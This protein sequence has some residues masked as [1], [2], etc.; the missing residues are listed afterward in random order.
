[1]P[2]AVFDHYEYSFSHEGG[3]G[4]A[5]VPI[6]PEGD[7]FELA[8][9]NWVV[10]VKA[11]AEASAGS[12][13]ATG[14][15]SFVV[16]LGTETQ[17]TVQLYPEAS[18]GTGTLNYALAYPEGATVNSF[19]LTLL[20]GATE[21]DLKSGAAID[22]HSIAGSQTVGSGY[23]LARAALTRNG[24]Q[25]IKAQVVH[26]YKNMAT[27]LSMEFA[28]A[29]FRAIMV[30]SSADSGPGSLR[31]TIENAPAGSAIVLDL[32]EN[33]RVIT[34]TST[35]SITKNLTIYGGGAT[36]TQSGVI[37]SLAT[38]T[39]PVNTTITV[40]I[41][42]FHFKGGRATGSVSA[43]NSGG[44]VSTNRARLT[45]ESCVFSDNHAN[46]NGGAVYASNVRI[47]GSTFYG[48]SAD[49]SGGAVSGNG[50]FTGNIFYG[51]T[52]ATSPAVS[53][54][55]AVYYFNLTDSADWTLG[56]GDKLIG[57]LPVSPLTFR[58]LGGGAAL[59]ML[60]TQPSYAV[61]FYGRP[62]STGGAA[63]AAQTA[64]ATGGYIRDY[65]AIGSGSVGYSGAAPDVD[66]IV[67]G[68]VTLTALE[69]PD[70]AFKYW[71][72][73]GE[74]DPETS[75]TLVFN[76][77]AHA[78]IRAVFYV[79]IT[80]MGDNAPGSLRAALG[81]AGRG[82]G[83]V[84]PAGSALS[85]YGDLP[86]AAN[87]DIEGNGST[88]NLNGYHIVITG[89]AT[90]VRMSRLHF[91]G[92][93]TTV[94]STT[95]GSGGAIL[96][97][98]I[99]TVESCIFS[100]NQA[101]LSASYG[102]GA[103]SSTGSLTVLGSTFYKNSAVP[104]VGG[105]I[106]A[107]SGTT[108]L[109]GNLF[110][111]NTATAAANN[112]INGAVSSQGFNLSDQ[113]VSGLNHADDAV[114]AVLPFTIVSF[115]PFAGEAADGAI[116]E[117]PLVYPRVDFYG[118]EV[119]ANDAAAGAVQGKVTALGF[120]LD[121]AAQGPGDVQLKSGTVDADGMVSGPVTLKAVNTVAGTFRHW[122]V[123]GIQQPVQST[124]NE[125]ELDIQ[126][127]TVVRAVFAGTWTVIT[128]ANGGQGSFREAL[129]LATDGDTIVL[130]GQTI[131]LTETLSEITKDLTI[132]GNGATLTQS[133]FVVTNASNLLS[134]S[135]A[136]ASISRI[137]FKGGRVTT[138]GAGVRISPSGTLT[139]ES[140][141]FSDNRAINNSTAQ[142]GAVYAQGSALNIY[143]CTFYDNS[144]IGS[145]TSNGSGGAI[146]TSSAAN[147]VGNVF[148]GNT[149]S[150]TSAPIVSGTTAG[151]LN[152]S[153]GNLGGAAYTQISS[154][155]ILPGSFKPFVGAGA[156]TAI[157][158]KPGT[159]PAED[160][161]GI[162][163]PS[164]TAAAGAVQTSVAGFMLDYAAEGPG[165]VG[166]SG[167]TVDAEGLATS[168]S[169]TLT[170]SPNPGKDFLYWIVNG[171]PLPDQSTPTELVLS[172][173][174]HKTV[175][176]AFSTTWTVGSA[177]NSGT[178]SLR[179]AL[180]G[181]MDRDR[182]V[183][184]GQTIILVEPLP[185]IAKSIT[186]EGNG[187][188]LTQSG[189]A[190]DAESQLLYINSATAEVKI[191]RLL[192]KGGRA[193]ANGAAIQSAGAKLTLES[194]I[195]SD[196]N[197]A[198]G[199]AAT[200]G[201]ALYIS[202]T[203]SNV[204]VLGCTFYGNSATTT[205]TAQ[206]GAIF[207]NGNSAL[208]LT[209]N[210]FW[211]NTGGSY[212][213][214]RAS[215]S[216]AIVSGGYNITDTPIG[217]GAAQSGWAAGSTG[218]SQATMMPL[219]S[220]SFKPLGGGEALN[221]IG[222][223]PLS[224]PASDFNG[225]PITPGAASGAI[226]GATAPGYVLDYG[227]VG[228]G[229]VALVA[230]AVD[231]DGV[232]AALSS[233]TLKATPND[234]SAAF[235]RWLVN[236]TPDGETTDELT[237]IMDGHKTVRAVFSTTWTVSSVGDAGPGTLREAL[238]SASDGDTIYLP[239]NQTITLASALTI[240]K[241]IAI[242]GGGATLTTQTG[243]T[244]A[245][246]SQLL[247][248]ASAVEVG[249]SRLHFKG[250]RATTN[251][252]AIYNSTGKLTLESCIFSDN[253]TTNAAGNGGA[254][255]TAG[256][257][258][259]VTLS[260]CTFYGNAAGTTGGRGAAVYNAS[261]A[262][263]LTGN[264]FWGN[265][266]ND[267]SVLYSGGTTPVSG[268]FNVS[269]KATGTN[270]TT[271]S[272]WAFAGDT[273]AASLPV[274]PATF[275][276]FAGGG[277]T[278]IIT[279]RPLGYPS[280]DFYGIAIPPNGAAAGAVQTPAS[281]FILD[282]APQGPG[283]VT[284]T[285]GGT[286]DGDGL[287]ASGNSVT[288]TAAPDSGRT[289]INWTVNGT[290]QPA[291]TP[292]EKL[293][294]IMDA[295]KT[296]RAI[297]A[298]VWTVNAADSG[299][300]SLREALAG[301]SDGDYIVL[302]QGQTIILATPLA[303]INTRLSIEGN[304]A[305]LTQSGFAEESN[306]QLLRIAAE[307]RISRLH[308][309]GG[310][311]TSTGAAIYNTAGQL[312]L[313]SCIFTDNRTSAASA[314]GGAIYSTGGAATVTVSGCTFYGNVAGTTGGRGGAI[315]RAGGEATLRGNLFWGNTANSSSVVYFTNVGALSGG[316]NITDKASGYIDNAVSTGWTFAAGDNQAA[317]MPL[318]PVSLK[319]IGGGQAT[320]IITAL[321][322][323]YP[324]MD[325]NGDVIT[326]PAAAGAIQ[327]ATATG[328][329]LD[330]AAQGLGT[331]QATVGNVDPD[332]IASYS[333]T[334]TAYPGPS[335]SFIRWLVN[336]NE[337][338]EP[339]NTLSLT[340]N[341]HKTVRAVF[342]ATWAVSSAADSGAGS[343]REALA[344]AVDGD[345]IELQGQTIALATPLAP[346]TK[347]LEIRGN[348]ATLTT[349]SG[350]V[351]NTDTQLLYINNTG[352][353]VRISRLHFKGGRA[354]NYGGAIRT[355]G[356][357][358]LESCI[359]SGNTTSNSGS[360]GGAIFITSGVVTISGCTF[361]GNSA[362]AA[363]TSR[364]GAIYRT[365]GTVTLTGNLFWG[366]TA[367]QGSVAYGTPTSGGYNITDKP[368]G[369]A[370]T[371]SG[372]SFTTGDDQATALPLSP[373]SL[374]PIGGGQ[375]LGVI[376]S[377]PANY[378]AVDFYG[379]PINPGAAAGAIQGAT[380][381]GY[382]LDYA[383]QGHGMVQVSGATVDADG[384]I[385][386]SSGV[387]L[388]ATPS[389][390][391][392]SFVR[393]LVNGEVDPE[394]SNVL[395][396]TMNGH[397]TV[398][399]VFAAVWTA[400][401]SADSGAGSLR[402]A[403]SDALAGDVIALQGQT[404]TLASTLTINKSL[405]IQG[406][407]ATLTQ[408]S[409]TQTTTSQLLYINSTTAEVRI[410]RILFTGGRAT[411]NGGAIQNSGKLTLE[412]C[413]FKDNTISAN[414]AEGGAIRSTN[415]SSAVLTV[416]GCTFYENKAT[417]TSTYGGAISTYSAGTS[418]LT[419][420]I[421]Q[422]NIAVYKVVEGTVASNGY[423]VSDKASGAG[424]AQ[425]GWAF[426]AGDTTLTDVAFDGDHKPSSAAGLSIMPS[427]L[428]AGFPTTY[429]DGTLRGANST[430]GAMPSN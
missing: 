38:I 349:Q 213:V 73:N 337:D 99:L 301:A 11:Y 373:V 407:G 78:T 243:F 343:L 419:G 271:G 285:S 389:G 14:S 119:P 331:V 236:G 72:V 34:L 396:L 227:A 141:I 380:A 394:A 297:F 167:G 411:N 18:D 185:Q 184:Q 360:Y 13:A 70:G 67:A 4:Q 237:L 323:G 182:I 160:F 371:A 232:I 148:W 23:Y 196:N 299:T 233:A 322:P 402:Q 155:P 387:T 229:A 202:G 226:Q 314:Q 275:K 6:E 30:F 176:A 205:G 48:N 408:N 290:A 428:P 406:N 111:G 8:P 315:Y 177:A 173:D 71:L 282:Y 151:S 341:E 368:G 49:G 405:E 114:A 321:P 294:L 246:D 1:M 393:W 75:A 279:A 277:A 381:T 325:F 400:N 287:V 37:G 64:T 260:G 281:G 60:A 31:E 19:N 403:V 129:A 311:A 179:Q 286:V 272:G 374:K 20:A 29:D 172:M 17:V 342:A 100:G 66:G 63:G 166:V 108:V 122:T 253:R 9:G 422:G 382:T 256:T 43:T 376:T 244:V 317:S 157:A 241:S 131:T 427:S 198:G 353:V 328:Y 345:V 355:T 137:H 230:T 77:N 395:N 33:D 388:T 250:G 35:L 238:D 40:A 165:T 391:N 364:G 135:G 27:N 180:T 369:T 414:S 283:Q 340:M 187:A 398:L 89:A 280:A 384:I 82:G 335:A 51:N 90:E 10:A 175:R 306:T 107:Q 242:M 320:G 115:R 211:G 56:E 338:P 162:T 258:A 209:G 347:S 154:L 247:R 81:A 372:F 32:P 199:S 21:I 302:P 93:K 178:G 251:G 219:S 144:A 295:N 418:I 65:A 266:S 174:G 197:T 98:G 234:A 140:C 413:I 186:I 152:V 252:A 54:T 2:E 324:G 190:P 417:G 194:C 383:A 367:A 104:G 62:V 50:N 354:T 429:F 357:L 274:V 76:M 245:A 97:G 170:A 420:N 329:T 26:I 28:E 88:L 358:A 113:S 86:I 41:N 399:A 392:A 223:L 365:T 379:N 206:G 312:T 61:D 255:Y 191:S 200:N 45:L 248:I 336:G 339:S 133:G 278:G 267:F 421:F 80:A 305:T 257:S 378:P 24:I 254:L 269:D 164:T 212:P 330:Y 375:A 134:F 109:Q 377:L 304:G 16:A 201:G 261:G 276:P 265:T 221:V 91:K 55:D 415:N 142:G 424:N 292:P 153:D 356:A 326:T 118:A 397:K 161:Y 410:S 94:S 239:A 208:T 423:N 139:L 110:W 346:L 83:I 430:P 53:S 3:P 344:G 92:G 101:A 412:S 214:A 303:I 147:L 307:V 7:E 296:V 84:L 188:T 351:P 273:T 309:K 362:A 22:S 121:Y 5:I 143:S 85:L 168:A 404:I 318:S 268:G 42:R 132:Q 361:Y 264:V 136:E 125:L 235:V 390:A 163:I 52:A 105:A 210:I 217:A 126:A 127:H 112:V 293:T 222:A 313:E 149:A 156:D 192:F 59:N 12:L 146:R 300:G 425:S 333:V 363:G 348:G 145:T 350:F 366:N 120:A 203:T 270:G 47:G 284:L 216:P 106:R 87:I 298:A 158:S 123:D 207:R 25:T 183:L 426:V 79:K 416:L 308:F 128:D 334:L 386:A 228:P 193:A 259:S 169:V 102:G 124:P 220:V 116:T 150:G 74:R 171:T 130:Q 103:I 57:D 195:F 39:G 215:G 385:A 44:A 204:T 95:E 401:S 15:E 159:Y 291:Q 68:P 218:D 189:F 36:L 240:T 289:F 181:A 359:F 117:R 69:D 224:Y 46:G 263:T 310:R 409:F 370:A 316:Y 138:G 225:I 332:G 288:L 352:A 262:L 96:N 231:A 327:S 319:P 249:I 58:P